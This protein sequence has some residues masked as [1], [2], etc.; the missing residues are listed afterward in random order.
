MS[1]DRS[2]RRE[3]DRPLSPINRSG[4][5]MAPV[6]PVRVGVTVM[7]SQRKSMS[8]DA[9]KLQERLHAIALMTMSEDEDNSKDTNKH[10]SSSKSR[11]KDKVDDAKLK[12]SHRRRSVV[13]KLICQRAG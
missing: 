6:S 8:T 11:S 3:R 4:E 12:E 7:K 1:G 2:R 9:K 10:K 13:T 5:S